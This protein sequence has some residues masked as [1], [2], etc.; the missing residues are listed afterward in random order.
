MGFL[1]S[2]LGEEEKKLGK[3]GASEKEEQFREEHAGKRVPVIPFRV[4]TSFLP[5]RLSAMKAN[6]VNLEVRL[7]NVTNDPQLVSVDVMLPRKELLGFDPACINKMSEKRIGEVAP[8]ETKQVSIPIWASNQ[9]PSGDY[10]LD[11]SVYAHYQDYNKVFASVQ[12]K[13]NLRVV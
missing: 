10:G 5:L 7:T 3:Q 1:D 8:G 12:R 6:S 2:L 9:T 4:S 11:V 13:T